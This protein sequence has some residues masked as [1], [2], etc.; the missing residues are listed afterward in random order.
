M[1][2]LFERDFKALRELKK[3]LINLVPFVDATKAVVSM[4]SENK[5]SLKTPSVYTDKMRLST[6]ELNDIV[7][8]AVKETIK[9]EREMMFQAFENKMND[10]VEKRDQILT[11]QLNRSFGRK[12]IT[13]TFI[14]LN[15]LLR[16]FITIPFFFSFSS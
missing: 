13:E 5:N 1:N 10:V 4:D 15:R 16:S 8:K 7:Q 9:K 2:Y 14:A 12:A 6:R 11:Q 3:S